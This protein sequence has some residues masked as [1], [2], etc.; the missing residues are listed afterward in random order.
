MQT[1]GTTRCCD[2][3]SNIEATS[4]PMLRFHRVTFKHCN[5]I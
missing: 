3:H 1:L 5:S 2:D 4:G